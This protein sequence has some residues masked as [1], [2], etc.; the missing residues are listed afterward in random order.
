VSVPLLYPLLLQPR[1][2]GAIWG[3]DALVARYGKPGDATARLGES[4]ECWDENRIANGAYAGKS[5]AEL[6]PQLGADLLGNL[7]PTE[8]FPILTKIIDARASLSVQVHPNDA[9]AQRVEHQRNGK[10][11]CWYVLEAEPGAE[12]VLGWNRQMS[13]AEY[14]RRVA[15]GSLSDVL[16]RVAVKRGNAFYLPAGTLHAIGAGIV[17]F[18]TQQASDLTYRI[19][20]WNRLGSDGKPRELHVQKAADVLD[21]S[22]SHAG[23]I[24][25]LDY[26]ADGIEHTAII[27]DPHFTVERVSLGAEPHALA[28]EGR[29]LILMALAQAV[30]L[31]CAGN[32][33]DLEP[34]RTALVPAGV[35]T[36]HVRADATAP[37]MVVTPPARADAMEERLSTA[38]LPNAD[39]GGFLRQFQPPPA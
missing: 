5:I 19:F 34:Y 3:G 26:A 2:V 31:Q 29:P 14:E 21:Y 17:I 32:T 22:R 35:G 9:Y 30:R 28:T 8:I 1:L 18:E 16:R 15:D 13:R 39:I 27:A 20:D 25:Q 10:T 6:R 36:M 24:A 23:A 33:T 38:G 11:E 7:D 37:L 4:W 12:I